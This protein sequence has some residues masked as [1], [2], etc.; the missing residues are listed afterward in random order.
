MS[1]IT[2]IYNSKSNLKAS[3]SRSIYLKT[4]H[5]K[6]AAV[7]ECTDHEHRERSSLLVNIRNLTNI[8]YLALP[9]SL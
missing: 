3:Q 9:S 1:P 7:P 4:M 6:K 2:Q 5:Q 8:V